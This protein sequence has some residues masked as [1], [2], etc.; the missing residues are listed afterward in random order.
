MATEDSGI[1]GPDGTLAFVDR[2]LYALFSRRADSS[3]HERDRH[4]YRAADLGTS[5]DIYISRVYGLSW[6]VATVTFALAALV[7]GVLPRSAL[8]SVVEFAHGAVP[9]LDR[10]AFPVVPPAVLA[11]TAGA[12]S[13][14]VARW[15]VLRSGGLYLRWQADARRADIEATLPGAVRYLRVLASGSSDQR[16][17]LRRV[18]DQHAYGETA[19]AFRRAL[20]EAALTG[21]LDAGLELV[22]R[23][24]PSRDLL[25]PFLLKY[26]EHANQ[27]TDAL[28]E[29]LRMESR[30]L[31]HQQSRTH[32]RVAG[33][34]ELLAELFVVMLVFPALTVLIITVMSVLAPGLSATVTTPLGA[35]TTREVLIYSSIAFVLGVGLAA[36]AIVA[37]LRPAQHAMP[38]YAVSR[39]LS[40][41]VLSA[42]TNPASAAVVCGPF[43]AVA[44]VA[45]WTLGY[46]PANVL[47]LSYVGFGLPVGVVAVR[48][49]RI[50]DAKDREI[51]DFVHAIAGHVAL[52]QPFSAAVDEVAAEVDHGA[53]QP[54][55]E[56]LAFSLSLT[57]DAGS[58]D[59]D[60]RAAALDK[61]VDDVGTPMAE[62][63]IGLV[64]GALE[65]GSDTE[66][67]FE[68]LQTE[69]G[70]LYH[71]RKQLRSELLVYVA[72]GWTTGLLVLGIMVA[73]NLS[74][75]D[76]FSQ[77]AS[78]SNVEGSSSGFALDPDAVQPARE[79]WR[80]YLVTQ[81]TM[82]SCGWFAGMASRGRYE[83][84]L[85][86][87]GLVGI[88]YAV[89][90][91]A[92]ML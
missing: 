55:V 75:L 67:V 59:G 14:A 73:V 77:L 28:A 15:G 26:R 25:A 90:A 74:V 42:P 88:T 85:H 62:Q 7:V 92:G 89:F 56:S 87:A 54:D 80:F 13:G 57:T 9:V 81:A 79:Q 76:G 18:A 51:R 40:D 22:A 65:S 11:L 34:L 49:A 48:R 70:T 12:I 52:G 24:T 3:R 82:L 45:L 39:D 47:L 61:F 83:A 38:D 36:A 86:S 46:D 71:R 21:S 29:Y 31:S 33:Y 72:V 43:A 2:A 6:G 5:F 17:M 35:V 91:G 27:G 41:L 4:R 50:D 30:L 53:L 19:T 66:Q 68:A 1:T 10:V 63:T 37:S 20:N 16:T 32:D 58:G 8:A 69:I 84:L 23:D 64:V 44:A 60:V 78:V